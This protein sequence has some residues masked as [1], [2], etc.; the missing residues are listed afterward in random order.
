M[1][2]TK[3]VKITPIRSPVK[4]ARIVRNKEK[5]FILISSRLVCTV[6]YAPFVSIAAA[7]RLFRLKLSPSVLYRTEMR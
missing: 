6:Q 2:S 4:P 3:A 7:R 5:R 1:S